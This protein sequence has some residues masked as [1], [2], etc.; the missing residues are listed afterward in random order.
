MSVA[1]AKRI[2]VLILFLVSLIHGHTT[3][4]MQPMLT[5]DYVF[6]K[7]A[8]KTPCPINKI[9]QMVGSKVQ[10]ALVEPRLRSLWEAAEKQLQQYD[11]LAGANLTAADISAIYPFSSAFIRSPELAES[12]PHCKAWLD[13]MFARPA[14]KAAQ[15]KVGE[16]R[17]II[18]E[19]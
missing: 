3:G 18:F 15:A 8:K 1:C 19:D 13:R 9:V 11:Y 12:Y 2:F 10:D 17:T 16:E 5:V 7:S 4:S 6:L 14:F